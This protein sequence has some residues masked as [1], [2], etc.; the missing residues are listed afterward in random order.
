MVD[1][2]YVGSE[3]EVGYVK[4]PFLVTKYQFMVLMLL[5]NILTFLNFIHGFWADGR[6]RNGM[7]QTVRLSCEAD[8]E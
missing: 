8:E 1:K 5:G 6:Q 7:M 3:Y 4:I 2:W